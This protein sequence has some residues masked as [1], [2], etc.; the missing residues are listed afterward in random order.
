MSFSSKFGKLPTTACVNRF[1]KNASS[2]GY[3]L[4][5]F[6]CRVISLPDIKIFM[7]ITFAHNQIFW[8]PYLKKKRKKAEE[9]AI[10]LYQVMNLIRNK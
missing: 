5:V 4:I 10:I 3:L 9:L 6:I 1:I 8:R 7:F 2:F